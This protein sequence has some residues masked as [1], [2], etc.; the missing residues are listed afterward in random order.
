LII[1]G[2]VSLSS[3]LAESNKTQFTS[4]NH[5]YLIDS[6][7]WFVIQINID[8]SRRIPALNTFWETVIKRYKLRTAKPEFCRKDQIFE[9]IMDLSG[10][11]DCMSFG[12]WFSSL[13]RKSF[14]NLE[15]R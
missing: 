10:L 5:F 7:N 8:W 4:I 14:N 12:V 13:S 11:N 2:A 3:S 9:Q 1:H 6:S 15:N